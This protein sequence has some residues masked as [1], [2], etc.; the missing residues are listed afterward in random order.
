MRR[1]A[2]DLLSARD[3]S[4][5]FRA[6]AA[7]RNLRLGAD[8]RREV[9]LIFKET[10]NNLAK[11]A[12]CTEAEVEFR[13]AGEWLTVCVRDNGVGFDAGAAG[14]GHT[15]GMGGHGLQSMRRRAASLGGS[16]EVESARGRGTTVTLRVPLG[17]GR[18]LREILRGVRLPHK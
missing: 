12:R 14:N 18:R 17:G 8:L 16:Y 10:V 11:H 2:D 3:I 9:Y 6:P 1:F 7:E 15:A 5:T 4:L 13:V